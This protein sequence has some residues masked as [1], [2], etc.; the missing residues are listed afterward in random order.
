MALNVTEMYTSKSLI[1]CHVNFNSIGKS[2]LSHKYFSNLNGK[3]LKEG[4]ILFLHP[5]LDAR[6]CILEGGGATAGEVQGRV[7]FLLF[8]DH[9]LPSLHVLIFRTPNLHPD[10]NFSPMT[11]I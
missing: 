2:M 10:G 5:Q 4:H 1:L 6:G 9:F 3:R 7:N 8:Q 11:Y